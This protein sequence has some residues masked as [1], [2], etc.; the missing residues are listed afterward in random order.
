[1]SFRDTP[2][3]KNC[4]VVDVMGRRIATSRARKKPEQDTLV[5]NWQPFQ[6]NGKRVTPCRL[7]CSGDPD[8]AYMPEINGVPIDQPGARINWLGDVY[9]SVKFAV[10]D[11]S[12]NSIAI[13]PA[14]NPVIG[15]ASRGDK[16]ELEKGRDSGIVT[17]VSDGWVSWKIGRIQNTKPKVEN[18]LRYFTGHD[19]SWNE[20]N[21]DLKQ[22]DVEN[23]PIYKKGTFFK[24]PPKEWGLTSVIPDGFTAYNIIEEGG[25]LDY[26]FDFVNAP[27]SLGR[28]LIPV[29]GGQM[30]SIPY[31]YALTVETTVES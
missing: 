13:D 11:E 30:F 27:S 1:M 24:G 6:I 19:Q 4:D 5:E 12:Y 2:I 9:L 28:I 18:D 7:Q 15:P 10:L 16:L 3:T 17:L 8:K 23:G 26:S 20:Y 22:Y 29:M 25:N 21:D 31:F 14:V